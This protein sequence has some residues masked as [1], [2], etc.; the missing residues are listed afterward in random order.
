MATIVYHG[1]AMKFDRFDYDKIGKNATAEGFGFYFTSKKS[2]AENYAHKGYLYTVEFMGKKSLSSTKKTITKNQ[3]K[4]FLERLNET[5]EYLSNYGDIKYEG[6]NDVLQNAVELEWENSNNDVDLICSICNAYGG[7][8]EVLTELYNMFGYD[9]IQVN[10]EWGN[11][12]DIE[13][14]LFIATVNEA[15]KIINVEKFK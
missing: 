10:A 1:S 5:G 13:N 3:L 8:E 9:H 15:F 2:I 14:C 6:F 4:K 11:S 12:E 7:K